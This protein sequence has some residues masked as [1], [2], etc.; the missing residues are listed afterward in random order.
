MFFQ[1]HLILGCV[2][3]DLKP[4]QGTIAIGKLVRKLIELFLSLALH[5]NRAQEVGAELGMGPDN[6]CPLH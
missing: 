3:P 2:S 4:S 5:Q 1:Y 6:G